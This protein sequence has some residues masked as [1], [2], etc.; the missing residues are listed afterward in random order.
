MAQKFKSNI[1]YLIQ[2]QQYFALFFAISA[3]YHLMYIQH[4]LEK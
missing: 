1:L 3:F 2:T 4:F